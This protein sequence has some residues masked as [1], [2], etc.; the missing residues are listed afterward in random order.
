[1]IISAS[2]RTDIPTFYGEWFLR[3]LRAG[4]CKMVNPYNRQVCRV[5]LD[6]QS[7]DGFVFW[8]KN[9]GPFLPHLPEIRDRGYPF[10]VQLAINNYPRALEPSVVDAGRS[11]EH[12]HA[13][14][15]Q[16][17]PR[18]VV[19]RYDT[20]VTST[21]TPPEF[22]L[23]NFERLARNLAGASDEVVI[24]FAHVYRKTRRNLDRAALEQG[25]KWSD[26]ATAQK[27][28][29][30]ARLVEIARARGFR[31]TVCSQRDLLAPGAEDARCVDAERLA[32]VGGRPL[33]S[34][35]KG[36]RKECG[37]FESRDIGEYNTCPHGC[38]YC[39]AVEE[40]ELALARFRE[41]DP[42]SEFLFAPSL[43]A[44]GGKRRHPGTLP[45]FDRE[46]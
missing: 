17:G 12:A 10:V 6:R 16:F 29:V 42:H 31:L 21:L 5:A 23:D 44:E 34:K 25:F 15:E 39:Y 8:T 30:V 24:S 45:L 40:R 4:Y 36:N 26:P 2:Y 37:C 32:A 7:V 18:V 11:V 41:H 38:A 1:M 46:D 3:R 13:L 33:W 19:W 35:L 43:G 28:A 22:H 20:I 9:V 14:R 27:L